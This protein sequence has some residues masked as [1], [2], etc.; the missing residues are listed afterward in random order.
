[1]TRKRNRRQ[2][3]EENEDGEILLLTWSKERIIIIVKKESR[4]VGKLTLS[5]SGMF[6]DD[7][8]ITR[9]WN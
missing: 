9:Q 1:M 7:M 6:K 5:L 3:D 8:I 4:K 2:G